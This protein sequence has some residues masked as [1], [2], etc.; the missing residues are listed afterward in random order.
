MIKA[1]LILAGFLCLALGTFG[2]I[3]PGLP[4]TP[5]VLLAAG[6][7]VRS[8]DRLYGRLLESRIYGRYLRK[9]MEKKGMSLRVKITSVLLMWSMITLS[10]LMVDSSLIRG[11]IILLGLT[12]TVVM[13]IVVP[14]VD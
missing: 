10:V 1:I 2:I 9:Y 6:L 13:L 11:I 7:F 3:L 5:F 14:T 4:T 12:G 8:S